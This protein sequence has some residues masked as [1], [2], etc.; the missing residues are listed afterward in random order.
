MREPRILNS[1]YDN[2][3]LLVA[4]GAFILGTVLTTI[5]SFVDGVT[6]TILFGGPGLACLTLAIAS[7]IFLLSDWVEDAEK[8]EDVLEGAVRDLRFEWG[9]MTTLRDLKLS[10]HQITE[11]FRDAIDAEA[12]KRRGH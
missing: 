8:S 12:L 6:G 7:S 2:R 11:L 5:A 4:I 3:R 1:Q 9:R 10:R